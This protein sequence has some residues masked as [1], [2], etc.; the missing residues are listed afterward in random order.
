M[1]FGQRQ[2]LGELPSVT[3]TTH[4]YNGSCRSGRR[5]SG[6]RAFRRSVRRNRSVGSAEI[7]AVDA[8]VLQTGIGFAPHRTRDRKVP[9]GSDRMWLCRTTHRNGLSAV[10]ERG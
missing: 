10:F 5:R 8:E 3:L 6:S 7:H 4:Q 1:T 9:F 2:T